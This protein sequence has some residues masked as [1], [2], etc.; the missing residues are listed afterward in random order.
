VKELA[1]RATAG[2]DWAGGALHF[3]APT[4][5]E[6]II[7]WGLSA[8]RLGVV[9]AGAVAAATC[10]HL[11]EPG[12][13]RGMEA[14]CAFAFGSVLAWTRWNGFPTGHWALL[15]LGLVYR[16]HAPLTQGR[17][18]WQP[19]DPVGGTPAELVGPDPPR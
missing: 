8:G 7:A 11:P 19:V 17:P 16:H 5:H 18:D 3:T 9:A 1:S 2:G 14:A 10:L 15:L 12:F 4:P 13:L 6:E